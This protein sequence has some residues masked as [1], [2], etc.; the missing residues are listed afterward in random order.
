MLKLDHTYN[1]NNYGKYLESDVMWHNGR[2][3]TK[4]ANTPPDT[5]GHGHIEVLI[6]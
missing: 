1:S 4:R 2:S 3:S 6:V 5:T